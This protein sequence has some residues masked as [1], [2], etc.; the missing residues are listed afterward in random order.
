[1]KYNLFQEIYFFF[2]FSVKN[3]YIYTEMLLIFKKKINKKKKF[4]SGFFYLFLICS[5]FYEEV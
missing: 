5:Y 2:N 1:M 4:I 3:V